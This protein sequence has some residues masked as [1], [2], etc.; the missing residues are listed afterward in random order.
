MSNKI[1]SLFSDFRNLLGTTVCQNEDRMPYRISQPHAPPPLLPAGCE[2]LWV[3][4]G[5]RVPAPGP[6]PLLVGHFICGR[7]PGQAFVGLTPGPTHPTPLC[8]CHP[9][10]W[11]LQGTTQLYPH[12]L[13]LE[14]SQSGEDKRTLSTACAGKR[15]GPSGGRCHSPV[16]E[17]SCPLRLCASAHPLSA[18]WGPVEDPPPLSRS[19]GRPL[20]SAG[21]QD[22]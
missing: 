13:F 21:Q 17:E 16:D 5:L 15:R 7:S 11:E 18:P 1:R 22:W 4:V 2:W 8:L 12:Y 20:C 3:S 14:C 9:A 19:P 10:P 6:P